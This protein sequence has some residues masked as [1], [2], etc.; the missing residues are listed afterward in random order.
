MS[1]DL[2]TT[3]AARAAFFVQGQM[4]YALPM[5]VQQ[6]WQR[7]AQQGLQP[8]APLQVNRID[9]QQLNHLQARHGA[10]C[11]LAMPA[12][13]HLYAQVANTDSLVLLADP[14][15]VVLAARGDGGF[16]DR[17][18][19]VAL[20][21]GAS[22][23]ELQMGTNAIGTAVAE[24]KPVLVNGAEH[25]F[26]R[27]GFLTCTASPIFDPQGRLAGVLDISGDRR[28]RHAH[29]MA[30]VCLAAQQIENRLFDHGVAGAITL[31]FHGLHEMLGT[32]AEGIAVFGGDGVLLAANRAAL[33]QL[34]LDWADI[35]Q[36]Y[37]DDVFDG[38]LNSLQFLVRSKLV[39]MSN[40]VQVYAQRDGLSVLPVTKSAVAH[41]MPTTAMLDAVMGDKVLAEQLARVVKV[42]RRGL[43]ILLQGETGT[44]K[45]YVARALHAAGPHANGPFVAV[46]CAA[47]PDGLIEAELFGYVSGA[48]TGANPKGAVG[49]LRQA[50]GGT[51]FLDEI[52]DMSMLLQARLLRVLQERLLTPLGSVE[53]IPLNFSLIT[54]SHRNLS[55]LVA[56]GGF[57][58]DLY[59][60]LNGYSLTLPA[61]R[62]RQGMPEIVKRLLAKEVAKLVN[63]SHEAMAI[64]TA[65]S[66]P[67]N[68]RQLR[69]VLVAA[70]ALLDED[71]HLIQVEHIQALL[72][73]P[74]GLPDSLAKQEVAA[75]QAAL[76]ASPGNLSA[77]ARRLGISRNTLY[78]R[79]AAL[80]LVRPS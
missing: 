2:A 75:I 61:L 37:C 65:Q 7:C 42:F 73:S 32:P 60:R 18:R 28:L 40:G 51:L 9:Q 19:R 54:A 50:H 23:S 71:D 55:A 24:R 49:K 25:Y 20:A 45:E 1:L 26:E 43:P 59:Y 31:R 80:G 35:G 29:R 46:N 11:R 8:D 6:S 66:W 17:A 48:F 30:L 21:P 76:A 16:L 4:P 63:V 34:G 14:E 62:T 52:G 72:Q 53:T 77:V 78:R 15:G 68:L 5:L 64:I 33:F 58:E 47:L 13:D 22:W 69:N 38:G 39:L 57:R 10:L 41:P 70:L 36:T 67:G 44:G 56:S 79:M 74:A 3:A 12:L 27:N